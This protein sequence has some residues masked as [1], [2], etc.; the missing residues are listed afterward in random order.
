MTNHYSLF[1]NT[2]DSFEDCWYPFFSLVKKYWPD[3][4]GDIYLN[5]ETKIYQHEGLHIIPVKNGL[6]GQKWTDCL[7]A[8][9]K[10]V[11]NE[12]I[13]YMQEDYFIHSKVNGNEIDT[14]FQV[15]KKYD[16]DCLHLTDQ[17]TAGPFNKNV[18]TNSLWEILPG[19]EYRISTQAAFWKKESLLNCIQPEMSGWEFERKANEKIELQPKKIYAVNQDI[20]KKG[21][22]EIIPYVFTGIIKGKWK[23]EVVDVFSKN[24]IKMDFKRRGIYPELR[25]KIKTRLYKIFKLGIVKIQS[26]INLRKA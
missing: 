4:K 7:I 15:F 26:F 21:T 22:N 8:G 9:L 12:N 18:F 23:K 3:Y 24:D 1:I 25:M 17:S 20:Y 19:A 10:K 5:T 11:N 13:I 6:V 2:T 14:F 16:C